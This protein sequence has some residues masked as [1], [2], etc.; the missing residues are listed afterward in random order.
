LN[1]SLSNT[2]ASFVPAFVQDAI[3]CFE[4]FSLELEE[5]SDDYADRTDFLK[6]IADNWSLEAIS[7]ITEKITALLLQLYRNGHLNPTPASV[8]LEN[9]PLVSEKRLER[10]LSQTTSVTDDSTINSLSPIPA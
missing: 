8:G 4:A 2:I 1:H 10:T 5:V 6:F 7:C 3:E 9:L